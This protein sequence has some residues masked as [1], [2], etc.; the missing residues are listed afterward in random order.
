MSD[1]IP[2]PAQIASS[3]D[4]TGLVR[5]LV[6]PF[7]ESPDSLRVDC[8]ISP[9][10]SRVLVRLAFEGEDKGRVFGRGGRNIQAIR[11][12]LQA[13]AQLAGQTANLEVFGGSPTDRDGSEDRAVS[14]RSPA[15][16]QRRPQ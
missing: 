5:F 15:R 9:R 3:P 6:L 14:T 1:L 12:V 4:Y 13:I 11:T 10:T 8:E 16:P 7:L 2:P